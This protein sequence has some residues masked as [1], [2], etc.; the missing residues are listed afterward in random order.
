MGKALRFD[1]GF[2]QPPCEG[3]KLKDIAIPHEECTNPWIRAGNGLE[4][5]V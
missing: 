3:S 2:N 5:L 4:A 1:Q